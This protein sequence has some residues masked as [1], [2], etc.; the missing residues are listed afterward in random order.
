[1]VYAIGWPISLAA[2][3]A[4]ARP[5]RLRQRPTRPAAWSAGRASP[6]RPIPAAGSST[7][8]AR[9]G[10]DGQ[11]R[12]DSPVLCSN[13]LTGTPGGAAPAERQPRHAQAQRRPVERR[14]G[15]RRGPGAVRR[16]RAAADRRPA[17]ARALRAAGQQLPRLRHPAV[18]GQPAA[19]RRAEGERMAGGTLITEQAARVPRRAARGRRAARAR[20]RHADDRHR[21]LRRRLALRL[22]G[23]DAAARQVRAA[24]SRRCE[25]LVAERSV[26]GRGHRPAAQHGRQRR[27]ARAGEPRLCPQPRPARPAGAAVGRALV[28]RERRA[29]DDRP[30]HEPGQARDADRQPCRG[31]DPA[32]GDRRAGG[33]GCSRVVF[34]W[35]EPASPAPLPRVLLRQCFATAG[36]AMLQ[37]GS[38]PFH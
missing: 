26:A 35:I 11:P 38:N 20:P 22:G 14:A 15:P 13:P 4:R 19:G 16:A 10:F 25:A 6:S 8:A 17:R 23:Q 24:T 5:A 18:L 31:G 3:P 34:T 2:R 33:R 7:T 36:E 21:V 27:P 12:G 30:G 37:I 1:M 9:P 32:G 29:G 28:D